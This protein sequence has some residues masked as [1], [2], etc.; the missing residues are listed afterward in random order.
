MKK[1]IILTSVFWI[2]YAQANPLLDKN[3][4]SS[5]MNTKNTSSSSKFSKA[6]KTLAPNPV[7]PNEFVKSKS[8][9][10]DIR[11]KSN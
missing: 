8:F 11:V 7:K 5:N 4:L 3:E 1:F 10:K 9:S 2:M 6:A